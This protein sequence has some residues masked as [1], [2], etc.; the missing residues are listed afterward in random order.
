MAIVFSVFLFIASDCPF[1]IFQHFSFFVLPLHCLTCDWPLLIAPLLSFNICPISFCHCIVCPAISGFWLPLWYLPT[2]VLFCFAIA[3]SVLWFAASDCPFFIFQH[4]AFFVLPWHCL[5][6]D[7]RLL[8][9]PLISSNISPFSCCHGIVCPAI[10][11]FWLPL[12]YLPTFVLF[13]FAI[14]LSVLR[15][16]AL[17]CPFDI[18]QHLSYFVLSLHCLS[19]DLP[20]L[21]APFLSSNIWHFSFCHGIVCPAICAS[22][23]PFD[24]FQHLSF[25]VLPWHCLSCDFRLLIAPLV[26]SNIC[27]FSFCHCIVCP[28][29]CGFWLPLCYL[30][31]FV[32]F[33]FAIA[34]SVLW[35]AASDCPFFIFQ[36]LSFFVLPLHCLSCDLPLRIAPLISSNICPILLCHC[37]VCPVICRF[38]LLLFYLPTFVL[39]RFAIALSVL[40]FAASDCPFG[41]FQ[42]LSFFVLPLHCLS[43]DL[44]LLI[45][46]LASSSFSWL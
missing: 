30:P 2:F 26:S 5:S 13:R 8:I 24:I 31:T 36:N 19:C 40:R 28:A 1:G 6:C 16:T 18:F 43:C 27:P 46:P 42:H 17:D 33:C 45:A 22:D 38:W 44:P 4:L 20:L 7:L 21:I 11:G 34:L 25:F 15:F 23:Y 3:L 35:F 9:T 29:I 32:L 41:I 14:A 10:C 39:F 12:W 37:N